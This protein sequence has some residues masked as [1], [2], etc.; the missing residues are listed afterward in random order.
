[1]S[2]LRIRKNPGRIARAVALAV[3]CLV[4]VSTFLLFDSY[5]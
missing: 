1:M 4:L 5:P 3:A 2:P